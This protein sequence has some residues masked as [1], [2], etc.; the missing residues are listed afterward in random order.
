MPDSGAADVAAIPKRASA[1]PRI[2]ITFRRAINKAGTN[3]CARALSSPLTGED[4]MYNVHDG[5]VH[6]WI[7]GKMVEQTS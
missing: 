6:R 7:D 4:Y 3:N 5:P 2:N 1:G